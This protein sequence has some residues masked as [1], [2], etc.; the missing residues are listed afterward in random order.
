MHGEDNRRCPPDG[1][2]AL[3]LMSGTSVDGLD[4]ASVRFHQ[5]ASGAWTHVLEAFATLAYPE[6]MRDALWNVMT[7]DA[8]QLARL[9]HEWGVWVGREVQSWLHT[10][11]LQ[12]H[13]WWG[14][15]ATPCST[16]Q[17][18]VGQCKLEV[19]RPYMLRWTCLWSAT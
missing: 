8:E 18:R 4:V 17:T 13:T 10:R 7:L 1:W 12:L 14:P 9:D 15:T 3:G 6:A 5:N 19:A 16:S 11:A 2:H